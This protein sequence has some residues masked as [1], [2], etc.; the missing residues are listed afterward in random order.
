MH[1]GFALALQ[2]SQA[3]VAVFLSETLVLGYPDG[4]PDSYVDE[5]A[6]IDHLKAK[7]DAGADFI[8]TQLFYDA[9]RFLTWYKKLR[10]KGIP[11]LIAYH[12][13]FNFLKGITIPVLPGIMPIQ[14]FSSFVRVTKLCGARI[15]VSMAEELRGISVR[16]PHYYTCPYSHFILA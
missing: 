13:T 14:T 1:R 11:S 6:Q 5:D 2:V 16:A 4:H 9:D 12:P 3:S 10:S 7:V 8:V 15:P